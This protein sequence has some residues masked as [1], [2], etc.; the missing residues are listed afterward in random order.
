[1]LTENDLRWIVKS[2]VY[3]S[4]RFSDLS[5]ANIFLFRST[6]QYRVSQ[7]FDYS[8]EGVSRS[9]AKFVLPLKP[10]TKT[11]LDRF[12]SISDGSTGLYPVTRPDFDLI[13]ERHCVNYSVDPGNS[14][15]LYATKDF[16]TF[17]G[18]GHRKTRQYLHNLDMRHLL[19]VTPAVHPEDE[20]E[21]IDKWAAQ[22]P[23]ATNVR[24]VME[25]KEAICRS[26]ELR[27]NVLFIRMC[28]LTSGLIVYDLVIPDTILILFSKV[29]YATRGLTAYMYRHVALLHPKRSLVN[30]CQDLGLP[31]LRKRKLGFRPV[32]RLEKLFVR[33]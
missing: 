21:F 25:C 12:F 9:G 30:L 19:E 14:D 20:L 15:Y 28:N 6:Y 27:L 13:K 8:L 5:P 24:D 17:Q 31:G 10:L 7:A 26:E 2:V 11:W 22:R 3:G 18:Q 4:R 33:W 23:T 16:A 29:L 1:M 32:S